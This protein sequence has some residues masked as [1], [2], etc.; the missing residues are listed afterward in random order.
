MCELQTQIDN[1]MN[2]CT[3]QRCLDSKT[4]NGRVYGLSLFRKNTFL[5]FTKN[6]NL[7][8]LNEKSHL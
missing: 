6:T 3:Y 4:L 1:Y 5:L 8:L 2:Y 7:K